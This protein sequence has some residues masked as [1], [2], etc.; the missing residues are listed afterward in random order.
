MDSFKSTY[1]AEQRE[2]IEQAYL[3]QV[4]RP[5]RRISDLAELGQLRYDG[6]PL[7]PF[8]VPQ[9]TVRTIALQAKKRRAG[10][11]TSKTAQ[12]PRRT[13]IETMRRRLMSLVDH[14]MRRMERQVRGKPRAHVDPQWSGRMADALRK[15]A[16]LPD[17]SEH[18]L[19][20]ARGQHDPR[21]PNGGPK[22]GAPLS[23]MAASIVAAASGDG[24]TYIQQAQSDTSSEHSS[25]ASTPSETD[26]T[27][28]QGPVYTPLNSGDGESVPLVAPNHNVVTQ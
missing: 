5:S 26:R 7:E 15:A 19:P 25:V 23:P 10:L 3:D 2:A 16:S 28:Q 13:A 4:I 8:H 17:E 18:G 14:E 1:T 21:L 22:G 11:A 12:Q 6:E 9:S 27:A 20:L 24:Q